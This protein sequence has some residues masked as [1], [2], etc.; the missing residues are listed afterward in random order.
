MIKKATLW[1][2]YSDSDRSDRTAAIILIIIIKIP[3]QKSM[4][5]FAVSM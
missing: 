4:L 3:R 2:N 5:S 1:S